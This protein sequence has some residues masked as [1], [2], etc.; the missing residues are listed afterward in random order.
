MSDGEDSLKDRA[1]QAA[2]MTRADY[3]K[4]AWDDDDYHD[5]LYLSF[6]AAHL[7]DNN[8]AALSTQLRTSLVSSD[9]RFVRDCLIGI[10]STA[11]VKRSLLTSNSMDNYETIAEA[12]LDGYFAPIRVVDNPMY[13]SSM[14]SVAVFHG[15]NVLTSEQFMPAD[16]KLPM[17]ME[18]AERLKVCM[19]EFGIGVTTEEKNDGDK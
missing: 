18:I 9:V 6:L 12:Y 3:I 16:S 15:K 8:G 4:F 1:V 17:N 10:P 13:P 5:T 14:L 19:G 2:L 11:I 7:A